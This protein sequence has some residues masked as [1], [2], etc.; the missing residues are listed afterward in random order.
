MRGKNAEGVCYAK[1]DFNLAKHPEIDV[2]NL[3]VIK[4]MQ[5]FK[6]KEYVRETFAWMHYY[7]YLTNDGIEFLRTYLNLPSEIVPATLKKSAKPLGRPLGGP[8]GDRPRGPPRDGDRPR[9]GDRDGYRGGP[10]GP[11]G[12]FGGEK[13][14]APADY[15]PNFR[16][17]GAR[18]GFGR[19]SGGF[20][21][22]PS[23]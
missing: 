11:P 14:G 2:P 7:W 19:G 9:F 21:G 6:S 1:K 13:G 16:G 18:P 23:S 15:Q 12:E 3:Q 22:A 10:R 8:G 4:L 20:G 5:S 17:T